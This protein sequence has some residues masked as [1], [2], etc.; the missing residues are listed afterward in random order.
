MGLRQ[1]AL[2]LAVLTAV[3][4]IMSDW[5][6]IALLNK[7]WYLPAGLLLLGLAYERWLASRA[8]IRLLL[9]GNER[10]LLGKP[11][12]TKWSW[13]HTLSR[14]V[15]IQFAPAAPP[16]VTLDNAVQSLQIEPHD[17]YCTEILVTPRQLGSL[18]W[19]SIKT[20]VAGV[21]GL[22]WWSQRA[23]TEF[24]LR[25]MP[26]MLAASDHRL[27]ARAVGRTALRS[28]GTGTEVLQLRDY[29][30]GDSMH[31]VDWKATARAGKLISRDFTQDQHLEV[32]L[33]I[34]AGRSSQQRCG[35]LDRLGH[36][37]NVAARFAEHAIAHDDRV[38]IVV[39]ADQPLAVL[40]PMRGHSAI[41]RIR[42]VLTAVR[43]ARAESNPLAAAV[44][45]AALVRHRSLV[46]MLTDLDDATVASQLA[47]AARLLL[48]KHL[49]LVA[50]L[51]STTVDQ[52]AAASAR[53]WLD[54]YHGLAAQEYGL[55]LH[56]N[57]LALRSLGA[58]A[59]AAHPEQL[60]KAVLAAYEGF[61]ARHRV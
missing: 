6:G 16:G 4:A 50:G 48:P 49:P 28:L 27:A 26:D 33:A 29:Q 11:I 2:I 43:S 42:S 44:R 15:Q 20:R 22:A 39:F 45:I 30:A 1:N 13:S 7:L 14:S 9:V 18:A 51:Q 31:T 52:L 37:V 34:D 46:V 58:P 23:Q 61:R 41:M 5:S 21:L 12:A 36:Y 17:A 56:R 57:V 3:I 47:A 32:I 24:S 54:P 38:G 19:P 25:V 10:A 35:S 55:R 59:L 40:P 8:G 60:E 53:N